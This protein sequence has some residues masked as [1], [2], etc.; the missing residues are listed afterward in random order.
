M[1]SAF[2][3]FNKNLRYI[4][5]LDA[6]YNHLKNHLRLPNDLDDLLRAQW[7]YCVSALDKLIHEL[8]RQGM[9]LSFGDHRPRTNKFNQFPISFNTYSNIVAPASTAPALPTYPPE[10]WFDQEI[11]QR[12]KNLSFQDPDK[13]GDILGLI[14][15]EDHKWQKISARLT[16]DEKYVKT[17]LRTIV[18][19][20]NQI[21]HEFDQDI[22]TGLRNPITKADS[23]SV[24]NFTQSLATV[25]FDFVK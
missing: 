19:R 7:V 3:Q 12:H 8:V 11:I 9:I 6:L 24:V 20:R 4:R 17:T 1:Q 15:E 25:I 22:V 18:I 13:I 16:L 10:Y 5:E 2:D 23:D 21:V 14:W